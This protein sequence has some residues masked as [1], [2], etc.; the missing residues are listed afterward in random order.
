LNK[1]LHTQTQLANTE[2]LVIKA[3]HIKVLRAEQILL[4]I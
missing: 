3:T 1:V 2:I 4:Q